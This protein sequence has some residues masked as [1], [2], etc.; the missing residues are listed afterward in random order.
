MAVTFDLRLVAY[1]PNGDRLGILNHPL[2]FS[3]AYALNDRPAL[4]V[5]YTRGVSGYQWLED[6]VEVAVEYHAGD[7]WIEPPNARFVKLSWSGDHLDEAKT[8]KMSMPGY[9]WL[10]QTAG[11]RSAENPDEGN[12]DPQGKRR[13]QTATAGVIVKT[14]IDEAQA[15]GSL[16]GLTYNFDTVNDSAGNPWEKVLT[17][18][19]QPG[20]GINQAIDNLA[21]QGVLD[22]QMQGR[23]LRIYNA[24]SALARDLTTTDNPVF[25]RSGVDVTSAPD[26]GD[27]SGLVHRALLRGDEGVEW[28]VANPTAIRPWGEFEATINQGGVSDEGTAMLLIESTLREGAE[29]RVEMTRGLLFGDRHQL[30]FRDY[31]IGDYLFAPGRGGEKERLRVHQTTMSKGADGIVQGNAVLNDRFIE[32]TIRHAKRTKGIVGG[33]TLDGGSGSIPNPNPPGQDTRTPSAPQNLTVDSVSYIDGNG[34]PRGQ[35]RALFDEVTT[36]TDDSAMEVVRYE[37]WGQLLSRDDRWRN[38]GTGET[39]PIV[40]TP[41]VPGDVWR[42]RVQAVGKFSTVPG[43]LSEIVE[44][45]VQDDTTPPPEPSAPIM[46]SRLGTVRVEWDG[47]TDSDTDMPL[48]FS[49][50]EV[51]M[52]SQPDFEP[53]LATIIDTYTGTRALSVLSDLPYNT[54]VFV[55]FVAVDRSGNKSNLSVVSSAEVTPLVDT[56]LIGEVIDG[57]NI[58]EGSIS[59]S[60]KIIGETI[61]GELI[62]GLAIQAGHIESNAITADKIEAGAITAEK[63]QLG[64]VAPNNLA[65]AGVNHITNPSFEDAAYWAAVAGGQTAI[66]QSGM[67]GTWDTVQVNSH[68]GARSAR[69]QI[70]STDVQQFYITPEMPLPQ[71]RR[72]YVSAWFRHGTGGSAPDSGATGYMALR[73][74]H[75]DG[76]IE[77]YVYTITPSPSGSW[78]FGEQVGVLPETAVSYSA[79]LRVLGQDSAG[80]TVYF[81]DVCVQDVVGSSDES[82]VQ[83]DPSGMRVFNG[84]TERI[85]IDPDGMSAW[86]NAGQPTVDIGSSGYATVTGTF[87]TNFGSP[88][89]EIRESGLQSPAIYFYPEEAAD[90][91]NVVPNILA[92]VDDDTDSNSIYINAGQQDVGDPENQIRL[93]QYGGEFRIGNGT[94][95]YPMA[96]AQRDGAWAFGINGAG[97][98]GNTKAA[99]R[100]DEHGAWF[101]GSRRSTIR[102]AVSGGVDSSWWLGPSR[103]ADTAAVSA[104]SDGSW[105]LGVASTNHATSRV[106][107]D[108]DG[109]WGIGTNGHSRIFGA[110]GTGGRLGVYAGGDV[111]VDAQGG[112]MTIRAAGRINISGNPTGDATMGTQIDGGL[113]VNDGLGGSAKNFRIAHPTKPDMDL[114]HGCT[115]S[116]VHGI[117]YWGVGTIDETGQVEVDLPEYFEALAKERNRSVIITCI[118]QPTPIAASA[119]SDGAFTVAGEPGQKFSWLV[120][121]ERGGYDFEVEQLTADG[122][123]AEHA[124]QDNNTQEL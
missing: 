21:E 68:S 91:W 82:R 94:A 88:R 33:A 27:A 29:E 97:N 100:S 5:S 3:S 42:I 62:Q 8:L 35:I 13:F 102:T 103:T 120:K 40:D 114:V 19:Y 81:D 59:A 73:L 45:T 39:P 112:A 111:L 9:G 11:V 64:A 28:E 122:P 69:C 1:E 95:E 89:V 80:G 25:L 104:G 77:Y 7:R 56:D 119:I 18:A 99:V 20:L 90:N 51:H 47:L 43:E 124:E 63:L 106:Y 92:W 17:I 31:R 41:Y 115:E 23:E 117:E 37:M 61:T 54:E 4:E 15:R 98:A 74:T 32:A 72:V 79:Y 50:V 109:N 118:D 30:P 52:S 70:A 10:L 53:T 14:I 113:W 26:K 85:R 121:A 58:V 6:F 65:G 105:W 16:P 96:Y 93:H 24:E 55:G 36:A 46:S 48:D 116:H 2:S 83:I 34:E 76:G 49:R 123:R 110:A 44:I 86:N 84:P 78:K 87:R 108:A 67:V 60:E 71:S 22:W 75:D 57:A 101:L 12:T 107:A 38:I 66:D